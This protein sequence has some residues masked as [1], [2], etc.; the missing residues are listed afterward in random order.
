MGRIS[1]RFAKI[2][3]LLK[4]WV[5]VVFAFGITSVLLG[6]SSNS[7]AGMP[8]GD[9]NQVD[10]RLRVRTLKGTAVDAEGV[11]VPGVCVGLFKEPEHELIAVVQTDN[12]GR[13]EMLKIHDGLYRLIASRQGFGLANARI[14]V[15]LRGSKLIV[16]RMRPKGIDTTSFFESAFAK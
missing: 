7:C 11:A 9:D 5:T 15:G 8:Y 16:I 10:Y 12:S 6:E 3:N 1:Q 14:V 2:G 13:F 4:A